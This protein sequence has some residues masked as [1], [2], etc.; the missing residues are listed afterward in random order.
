MKVLPSTLAADS[1]TRSENEFTFSGRRT[2]PSRHMNSNDVAAQHVRM[3]L[4][5]GVS[6]T[7]KPKPV[8]LRKSNID[9][10]YH[11]VSDGFRPNRAYEP[12]PDA[13]AY[14][15]TRE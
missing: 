2:S 10:S 14:Y 11:P 4:W 1:T 6:I 15:R 8:Y 13:C 7:A 3:H 9:T 12:D 5:D